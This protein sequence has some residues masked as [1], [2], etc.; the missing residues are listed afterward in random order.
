MEENSCESP[1]VMRF[2]VNQSVIQEDSEENSIDNPDL[3]PAMDDSQLV[4]EADNM[5]FD[6][7]SDEDTF[8]RGCVYDA[9]DP[10]FK[11]VTE[12]RMK[13]Y[14][15]EVR[16]CD[17]WGPATAD[18]VMNGVTLKHV[19]DHL[20]NSVDIKTDEQSKL[21]SQKSY[22]TEFRSTKQYAKPTKLTPENGI[23]MPDIW[24][25]WH[26]PVQPEDYERKI[27]LKTQISI[28]FTF[29]NP[30][31]PS[32]GPATTDHLVSFTSYFINPGKIILSGVCKGFEYTFADRFEVEERFELTQVVKPGA[33]DEPDP[34]KRLK[35]FS[36][37]LEWHHRL[38]FVK[39]CSFLEGI[40]KSEN[41]RMLNMVSKC[42]MTDLEKIMQDT[43]NKRLAHFLEPE[44]T[45]SPVT[46]VRKASTVEREQA[47]NF[48]PTIRS[49][50]ITPRSR[51]LRSLTPSQNLNFS[52]T[53][54]SLSQI[55]ELRSGFEELQTR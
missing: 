5:P 21:S 6:C 45:K 42:C 48:T 39:G 54:T 16:E 26:T 1:S 30:D 3:F 20:C 32:F 36:V 55:K 19:W 15:E 17:E 9:D 8:L 46:K 23:D 10:A 49:Q 11:A 24:Y 44:E 35:M 37:R 28:N 31:P 40:I 29:L 38:H 18:V 12:Q 34:V 50:S 33:M 47:I 22:W 7:I 43:I 4:E 14:R 13:T 27:P 51:S 2:T 25:D 53:S 52:M 41:K